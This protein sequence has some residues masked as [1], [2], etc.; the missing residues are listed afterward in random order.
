VNPRLPLSLL[1]LLIAACGTVTVTGIQDE[2]DCSGVAAEFAADVV[3]MFSTKGC[4]DNGCHVGSAPAADLNLGGGDAAA[5]YASIID[6]QAV[7][8]ETSP[9]DPLN[10]PI[11]AKPLN[12]L[13]EHE[14]GANFASLDDA[15]YATLYCW[16]SAGAQN[17]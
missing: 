7:D 16:I 9:Q 13:S 4:N 15:D 11:S 6:N 17:N 14:G 1:A 2:V 10:A 5:I 8:P 3:P 12:G